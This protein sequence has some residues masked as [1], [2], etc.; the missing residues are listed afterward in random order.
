[1]TIPRTELVVRV[2]R[3]SGAGGQ[4]VNKTSSRVELVWNVQTSSAVSEPQRTMLRERLASKLTE[5]GELRVVSSE[6]RSQL[7]NRELAERRLAA[8]VRGALVVPKVRKP[9]KPSRAAKQARLDEKK[10]TT[11][12]KR[13]RRWRGEE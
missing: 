6:T 2:S 3:S 4:H 9:T 12:K 5:S 10:R 7:Q 13:E 11:E 8:I 1:V